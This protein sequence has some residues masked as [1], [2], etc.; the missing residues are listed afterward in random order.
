MFRRC[1]LSAVIALSS[2]LVPLA[3]LPVNAQVG[4]AG[5]VVNGRVVVQVFVTLSDEQTQYHPIAGL[6][7]G[8]MRTPR[9]T[10]IAVTD[11]SGSA[12]VLLPPG[13][14]RV[15]SLAP[16][17]W[18]G[19]RYT[20][21]Q[22]IVVKAEMEQ[23]NLRRKEAMATKVSATVTTA[24]DGETVE[25]TV[26]EVRP[27]S[28]IVQSPAPAPVQTPAPAP[29]VAPVAPVAPPVEA[30]VPAPAP[31]PQHVDAPVKVADARAARP[32]PVVGGSSR[33]KGLFIGLDV[34]GDGLQT[35]LVGSSVESGEG[36]GLILGY[37]F[38]K[39]IALYTDASYALMN[40]TD[41]G[42]YNLA[43]ADLGFRFHFRSGHMFVPFIELGAT[44]RNVST[45]SAGTTYSATGVGGSA[46][47]GFNAYLMRS[48]AFST[49]AD[50]SLGN[51]T[52]YQID[53]LTLPGSSV[54]AQTAR[55]RVGLVW[56]P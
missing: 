19:W 11:R 5:S 28:A 17:H 49:S 44:G 38:T 46:G 27:A 47:L 43:H 39:R 51:F 2:A 16:T 35:N 24:S 25:R 54:N 56:F 30:S 37:G 20:W 52:N 34:Q 55:V 10:A 12:I 14:Y 3:T 42:T 53:N 9:D 7:L 40:A 1:G 29:V 50:W 13:Q 48:V 32:R 22:P 23:I 4:G 31:M 33:T 8:F 6:P 21:N 18:K 45:T 26:K 41:G 36:G 15:V